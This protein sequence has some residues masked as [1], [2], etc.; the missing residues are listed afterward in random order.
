MIPKRIEPGTDSGFTRVDLLPTPDE[1]DDHRP[2]R[3]PVH[4]LDEE[5]RFRTVEPRPAFLSLH[6]IGG[7]GEIPGPLG[8]IED[9]D[10]VVRRLTV[11]QRSDSVIPEVVDVLD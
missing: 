2:I 9:H 6:E 10:T 4:V 5:L 7:F 1:A 8:F 3:M 11:L